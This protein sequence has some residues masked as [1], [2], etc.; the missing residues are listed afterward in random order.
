VALQSLPLKTGATMLFVS[1]GAGITV[2]A[3]LY[4]S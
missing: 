1:V 2:V 3:A 4:R